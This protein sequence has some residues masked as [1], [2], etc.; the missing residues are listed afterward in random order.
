MTVGM[1][2]HAVGSVKAAIWAFSKVTGAE[3]L[4]LTTF[5]H[6]HANN[7]VGALGDYQQLLDRLKLL[8]PPAEVEVVDV[9]AGSTH[10]TSADSTALL[11]AKP[12]DLSNAGSTLSTNGDSAVLPNPDSTLS[13]NADAAAQAKSKALAENQK[14]LADEVELIGLFNTM[15]SD[16]VAQRANYWK[17]LAKCFKKL[18]SADFAS[19]DM[20]TAHMASAVICGNAVRVEFMIATVVG[21]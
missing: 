10:S 18:D 9:K 21:K 20:A 16:M 11:H 2:N 3:A 5:K 7:F 6:T 14:T 8:S 19:A 15:Y 13:T 12:T 4:L 17:S 1:E